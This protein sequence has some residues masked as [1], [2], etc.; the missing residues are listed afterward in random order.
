[1]V[2]FQVIFEVSITTLQHGHIL[3]ATRH[4]QCC[5]VEFLAHVVDHNLISDGVGIEKL[6]DFSRS[7]QA[8]SVDALDLS[9]HRVEADGPRPLSSLGGWDGARPGW[10]LCTLLRY[11]DRDVKSFLLTHFPQPD[12]RAPR[13]LD[14]A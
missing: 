3:F 13:R 12:F 7:L 11:Q 8:G 2:P 5:V 10:V 6:E 9:D 4:F 14:H 1:M